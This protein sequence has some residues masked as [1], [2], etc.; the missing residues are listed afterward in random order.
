MKTFFQSCLG[1]LFALLFIVATI[2]VLFIV[3]VSGMGPT[4]PP[5]PNNAILVLDLDRNLPDKSGT[6]DPVEAIQKALMGSTGHDMS[7]PAIIDALDRASGDPKISGLFVTGNLRSGGAAALL[8][9]RQALQRFKEKN[10]TIISYNQTWGRGELYLCAGLGEM[11]VNPFGA[12][13]I[14]APSASLTFFKNAFDKYG[15]EVQVT[16][17]GKYKSAVEP[18]TSDRM[19]KENEEQVR[20]YV[21][22]IWNGLKTEIAKGRELQPE[23]IQRLADTKGLL[24]AKGALDEKLVDQLAYYDAVL[25]KLKTLANKG[26][27]STDFP[28]I[29]IETY[30]KVSGAAQKS[31]NRIAVIV[32]EGDIVD[33]EGSSSEIGGDS[34]ARELR[35]LRLDKSVKAVVMRV[36]SPGGSA[37][38]SDVIQREIIAIKEAKKPVV[39]S[40]GN[41]AASG[42]Y[43]ISTYADHIFAEPATITGSIGVFGMFPNARK[44]ANN[45]GITFGSVQVAKIGNPSLTRPMTTEEQAMA[46]TLVDYVYDQF[47]LKVSESRKKDKAAIHEIAQG[48]VWTGQKAIE[49]GLVDEIGGLDAAIKHAAK[50]ANI[51]NDYRLDGPEPPKAPMERIMDAF[52]KSEK[53][54]LAK[55]GPFG[56]AQN[57]LEAALLRLRSLNDPNGVYAMAPFGV[58]IK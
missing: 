2:V 30:A 13:D 32:A 22:G 52:G 44:L 4:P 3:M 55:A 37:M 10:K 57:E 12:V 31:T 18:F 56:S 29:D 9:L 25:D 40:M 7:L 38:A 49:L 53:R 36:N 19:S 5:V 46:Q 16:K 39:V 41:V 8:E 33:G 35:K 48:R 47:L 50:L 27:S 20:A 54:K 11:F 45:Y 42:G 58:T 14:T 17:V 24:D 15:I 1:T 21:E 23:D 51:E 34:F 43:W 28:Q 6:D 26:G